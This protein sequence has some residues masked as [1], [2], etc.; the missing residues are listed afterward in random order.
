MKYGR[1]VLFDQ[2]KNTFSK[3]K[4]DLR[5]KPLAM[6]IKPITTPKAIPINPNTM[7]NKK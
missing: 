1:T 7:I 5:V 2:I 6:V 3:K 4:D